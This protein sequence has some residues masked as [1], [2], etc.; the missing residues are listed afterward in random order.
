MAD[1]EG[2]GGLRQGWEAVVGGRAEGVGGRLAKG[3]LRLGAS[4]YA[5]GLKANLGL[6]T[7]GLKA[8]TRPALPVVSVGNL[9]LGGT[10]KTTAAAFLA[11]RLQPFLKPV[12]VLRGYGR[13]DEATPLIVSD[14]DRLHADLERAGDEALMLAHAL[15]G[16]VVAVGKRREEVI[17]LARERAGAQIVVLDDG[18]QYFRMERDLDIV[19]LD[20]LAD[21]VA[22][23][24]FPAGRLR[25]P[26]AHLGRASQVWI[27]HADLASRE[28]VEGL[29]ELAG[30]HC[31]G[32]P[33]LTTRH[34][35]G[36]LRALRAGETAP[37]D[38]AGL[39]VIALSALGNPQ[40]FE[41][42]LEHAGADV[43]PLRFADHHAYTRA[44]YDRVQALAQDRGARWVVTTEKDAV[45]LPAPPEGCPPV[46]VLACELEIL[47][48]GDA[49]D[50]AL[51]SLCAGQAREPS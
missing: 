36:A 35:T 33:V 21:P 12:V 7:S 37:P 9:T 25:E 43:V 46:A 29:R 38:L 48:G 31:P 50:D 6:Y 22:W 2:G 39:R 13:A 34:R 28:R 24:L 47:A 4:L 51:R 3:A 15:P 5:A 20:A 19:L 1:A 49:V 18:F 32:R 44:D 10:G 14:G 42:A 40:A 17:A 26:V 11:R 8:R 16:C 45:K 27:T 30:R 23:R 41:M